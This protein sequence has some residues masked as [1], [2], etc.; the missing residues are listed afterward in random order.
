MRHPRLCR[1]RHAP[2]PV[3]QESFAP[4]MSW[5]EILPQIFS[6]NYAGL[7]KA[8]FSSTEKFCFDRCFKYFF[9]KIFIPY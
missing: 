5:E 2:S 4:G 3:F 8:D 1:S 7:E 9:L 6:A